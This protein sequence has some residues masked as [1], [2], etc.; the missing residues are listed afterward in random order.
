MLTR[1][2]FCGG[3]LVL[4]VPACGSRDST[5]PTA[6]D[7]PTTIAG[8]AIPGCTKLSPTRFSI[9]AA[10][11]DAIIPESEG[12]G[13][14]TAANAAYY[15]DRLLGAFDTSPPRIFAGGPY[16]G[17]HGGRDG[18]DSWQRLTRVEEIRWRTYLEGSL[19]LAEREFAGPVKGLAE[20]Y[21][22][23]LDALGE[24]FAS[25]SYEER[26]DA[27]M[28]ADPVF[29]AVL[30]GHAVEGTYGDPVYG[31]NADQIGWMGIDYEGDRQPLG[32]TAAQMARPEDG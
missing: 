12:V 9:L 10:A 14:A 20:V 2:T 16:S 13:G 15:L 7:R 27:L 1:R 18:F 29:V 3:A 8:W 26:R 23:G 31:G 24:S 30:Y 28:N 6:D 17:R 21:A 11:M 5:A 4:I 22:E 32:Y 25:A 19:G